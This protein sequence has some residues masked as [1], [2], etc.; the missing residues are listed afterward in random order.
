MSVRPNGRECTGLWQES[1]TPSQTHPRARGEQGK[2]RA[3]SVQ[4]TDGRNR[5]LPKELV[6]VASVDEGGGPRM[7]SP[8][9]ASRLLPSLWHAPLLSALQYHAVRSR[10]VVQALVAAAERPSARVDFV[11]IL[12][13]HARL[14][15]PLSTPPSLDPWQRAPQ[16][17]GCLYK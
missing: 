12:G 7:V 6:R 13:A 5:E 16:P 15:S 14:L 4:D 3:A 2:P 11:E 10:R 1:Q 8:A 9:T 17:G